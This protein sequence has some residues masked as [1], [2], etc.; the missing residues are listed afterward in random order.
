MSIGPFDVSEFGVVEL[1]RYLLKPGQRDVLIVLFDREFIEPQR[2]AGMRVIG[3]F[4]DDDTRT[5]S[6]GCAD[7]PTWNPAARR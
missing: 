1:R 2:D 5:R 3:A 6:R 7:S 4:R